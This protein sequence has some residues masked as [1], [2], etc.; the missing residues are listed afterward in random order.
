MMGIGPAE[1]G[2]EEQADLGGEL[3]SCEK[4]HLAMTI[5]CMLLIII[6]SITLKYLK[7]VL[8][9]NGTSKHTVS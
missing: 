9:H 4:H 8:E 1:G 6:A 7:T 5:R 2:G 3:A